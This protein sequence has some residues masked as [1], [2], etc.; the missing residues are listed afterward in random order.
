MPPSPSPLPWRHAATPYKILNLPASASKKDIKDRYYELAFAH[1]PD[2]QHRLHGPPPSVSR[3]PL[4]SSSSAR[5][6]SAVSF[7]AIQ[8][9][10]QVLKDDRLRREYELSVSRPTSTP[11]YSNSEFYS[12]QQQDQQ[13]Q[14]GRTGEFKIFHP[15]LYLTGGL[16]A[17][18]WMYSRQ[19]RD[20]HEAAQARAWADWRAAKAKEGIVFDS[21]E[22]HAPSS[23]HR[24]Q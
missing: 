14:Q 16:V 4:P 8:D 12:Y 1:H 22:S 23:S 9:A 19:V 24:R 13:Q 21:V 20:R 17:L 3:P 11:H 2:R 5:S 7:V 10:Y 15:F 6:A 18:M